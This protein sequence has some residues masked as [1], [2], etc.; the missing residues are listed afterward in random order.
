MIPKA[1][2]KMIG[3]HRA[4]PTLFSVAGYEKLDYHPAWK[5]KTY[6]NYD[7]ALRYSLKL[8]DYYQVEVV[9]F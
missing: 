4:S 5:H 3:L 7:Q 1:N 2:V 9:E 6:R 8:K